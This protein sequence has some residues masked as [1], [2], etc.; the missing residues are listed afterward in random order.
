MNTKI[1]TALS[2]AAFI[3]LAG[4]SPAHAGK[5]ES[6]ENKAK[7]VP[8]KQVPTE[9]Q[10]VAQRARDYKDGKIVCKKS[11]RSSDSADVGTVMW[12]W[13]NHCDYVN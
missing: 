6:A 7:A 8:A 9:E 2:T 5:G 3:M 11:S 12:M 10:E 13:S 1:I 4:L